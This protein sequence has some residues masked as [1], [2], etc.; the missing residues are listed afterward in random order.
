VHAYSRLVN[1]T[2]TMHDSS[3]SRKMKSNARG[4]YSWVKTGPALVAGFQAIENVVQLLLREAY[5]T[6]CQ[7]MKVQQVC[8]TTTYIESCTCTKRNIVHA[9]HR[10]E[11]HTQPTPCSGF[12]CFHKLHS[13]Q[14]NSVQ[15]H[16]YEVGT[17]PKAS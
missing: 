4:S 8:I 13:S 7:S 14:E 2:K 12:P 17:L 9:Q 1:R 6:E 11:L 15:Y 16:L 10:F 3:Q 5:V